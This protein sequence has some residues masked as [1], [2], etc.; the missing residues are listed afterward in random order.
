MH[1]TSQLARAGDR[2]GH[3]MSDTPFWERNDAPGEPDGE[4]PALAP[5]AR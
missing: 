2:E 1:S 5:D 4:A 3:G